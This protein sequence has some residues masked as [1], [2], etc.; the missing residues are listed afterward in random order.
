MALTY[1]QSATLM[2]D[3]EFRGRTQVACLKYATYIVDEP[4]STPAHATRIK[5]AQSTMVAPQTAAM[6]I[7]PTVVMDGAVQQDG[8]AITDEDLQ[9]AVENTINKMM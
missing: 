7:Q 9:S 5:W 3:E 8:A 4:P 1:E 2:A 6:I